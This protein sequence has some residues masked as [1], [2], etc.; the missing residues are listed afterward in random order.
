MSF[1]IHPY[2]V[3]LTRVDGSPDDALAQVFDLLGDS[4]PLAE[5]AGRL[6][7]IKPNLTAPRPSGSGVVTDVAVLAAFVRLLRERAPRVERVVIGDGPGMVEAAECFRVAGYAELRDTLGVELVDLNAAP[8]RTTPVP[9]WLRYPSLELPEIVLDAD[10]FVS[11]T[12]IKTHTDGLYTLHAKNMFGVP[13]NRFYGRPRRALHR[14]GVSEVVHDICRARP[15]DLAITDGLIG[16]ELGDPIDGTPVPLGVLAAGWNAQAVDVVGCRL[17]GVDP[18]RSLYLNYLRAAGY[19]PISDEEIE[20]A[21]AEIDAVARRFTTPDPRK[22]EPG[23]QLR[24][25]H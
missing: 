12:P 8:T 11:I 3:A 16:T 14:A 4:P 10:L 15:I 18:R 2:R 20:V 6:V 22:L 23:A 25:A 19:G 1:P 24:S 17:M 7:V 9:G 13:P 21:G 5:R